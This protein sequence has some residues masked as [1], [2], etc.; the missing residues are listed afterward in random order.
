MGLKLQ[1]PLSEYLL[2]IKRT[3]DLLSNF[4]IRAKSVREVGNQG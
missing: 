3:R 2:N 4:L 1:G